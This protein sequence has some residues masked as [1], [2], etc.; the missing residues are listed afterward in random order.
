MDQ[1][2]HDKTSSCS[3]C[4]GS[5]WWRS[6]TGV[7]V[8]HR[9]H[10]DPIEALQ[11]LGEQTRGQS[12]VSGPAPPADGGTTLAPVR[13]GDLARF[14]VGARARCM[15]QRSGVSSCAT[16]VNHTLRRRSPR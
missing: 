7:A 8:C 4:G 12:R 13:P 15:I 6:R 11:M 10:P 14:T 1:D 9:C 2:R 5:R 16:R 3:V